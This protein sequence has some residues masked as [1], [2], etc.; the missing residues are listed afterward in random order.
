LGLNEVL[1]SLDQFYPLLIAVA[2]ERGIAAGDLLAAE[3]AFDLKLVAN[4]ISA[5]QG[6]YKNYRNGAGLEQPTWQ[7]GKVTAGYRIGDGDFAPWYG[8]RETN[9]GGE[10][11][12]G[13]SLPFWRDRQIDKRRAE[14]FKA[15]IKRRLAEPKIRKQY[16]DFV[17]QATYAYWNWVGSVRSEQVHVEFLRIARLRDAQLQKLIEKGNTAPI[18]RL[19]NQRIVA[20]REAALIAAIRKSQK[21]ALELSL[22]WRDAAT[23]APL[24]PNPRMA[25][26]EFPVPQQPNMAGVDGDIALALMMSPDLAR[27]RLEREKTGVEINYAR[28]LTRPEFDGSLYASKDVGAQASSKGDKTPFE[29]EAGLYFEVPLQRRFALGS[30]RSAEATLAQLRAEERYL[31]DYVANKIRDAVTA[32]N[33]AYERISY[34]R[35][36]YQLSMAMEQAENTRLLAGQSTIL[37]VNFREI[38]TADAELGLIAAY[39][40]YY[41]ALA[42]YRAALAANT[43]FNGQS[44]P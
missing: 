30:L 5:P 15:D 20:S 28:N 36:A 39:V 8:E 22:F 37:V 27:I 24:V 40:D 12:T 16:L 25:P 3:G 42:D 11:A 21:A 38:A 23:S 31:A 44:A 26:P 10:F 35:Q 4:S 2:Q 41:F 17:R 14:L 6:F 18:E 33:A 1:I 7:G 9:E 19:D 32:L 29:L 34:A 43:S 13:L